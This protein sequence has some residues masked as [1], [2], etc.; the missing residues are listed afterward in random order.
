MGTR[1]KG[2]DHQPWYNDSF[3]PSAQVRNTEKTSKLT[4]DNFDDGD[5]NSDILGDTPLNHFS[6]TEIDE[7][8]E[9][10]DAEDAALNEA[11]LAFLSDSAPEQ[12]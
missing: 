7:L 9:W 5:P 8:L 12:S 1:K 11:F 3:E 4:A 6:N 2:Y 10:V